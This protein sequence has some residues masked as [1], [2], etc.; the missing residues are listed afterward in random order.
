MSSP[1]GSAT[2]R[3]DVWTC[4]DEAVDA[5]GPKRRMCPALMKA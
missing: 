3:P 5:Q 4:A 1:K 2:F